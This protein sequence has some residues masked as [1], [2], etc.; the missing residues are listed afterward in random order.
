MIRKLYPLFPWYIVLVPL[1]FVW[2]AANSLYGLVP[3]AYLLEY[4]GW[5]LALGVLVFLLSVLF[6]RDRTRAGVW[7][8]CF[9]LLFF[10]WGAGHD[11]L[12]EHF[13]NSFISTWKVLGPL[14]TVLL[15]ALFI[16]LKTSASKPFRVHAFLLLLSVVF[17]MTEALSSLLF[18][19]SGKNEANNLAGGPLPLEQSRIPQPDRLPDIFVFV[20]D[21]LASGAA[22]KK[23]YGF[24]NSP[25]DSQLHRN[26]FYVAGDSR[27]NYNSTVHSLASIFSGQYLDRHLE[28]TKMDGLT[29]LQAQRTIRESSIIRFLEKNKYSFTNLGLCELGRTLPRQENYFDATIVSRLADQT[30]W[31]RLRKELLWQV[32]TLKGATGT[33]KIWNQ[34]QNADSIRVTMQRSVQLLRDSAAGPRFCWSH[35]MITHKPFL[36][37]AH[38]GSRFP[39]MKDETDHVLR[40]SLYLDQV[41]YC[42]Q[43]IDTVASLAKPVSARPRIILLLGDH[44]N[45]DPQTGADPNQKEFMNFSAVYYSDGEYEKLYPT[46]SPVNQL[47]LVLNKYFVQ[48]L[49]L[50]KDSTVSLQ[51]F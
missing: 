34:V 2:H 7:S 42:N 19:V 38:G 24:D 35:L 28:G 4:S 48:Q 17:V 30:L 51:V 20:F 6:F 44:G 9:L 10:F 11:W 18:L 27:S 36:L 1:F 46:V 47:R 50:L 14:A 41:R 26:G 33:D 29:V 45:R 32:V 16:R 8:G 49:P 25:L 3:W 22:L 40:D 5:Y 37:D 12:R 13:G 23:F 43:F 21:E 31:G 39:S 15:L